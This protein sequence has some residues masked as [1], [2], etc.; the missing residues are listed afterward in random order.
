MIHLN[1]TIFRP[2]ML[3]LTGI[4]GLESVQFWIGI[5]FCAMYIIA[6]FGN[7][8]LLVV[9]KVERS[10]H[11]PMYLLLAMLGATDIALS[12][13]ILPKML[14]IFWFHLPNIYFDACLLQMWLIHTFQ[15]IESGILFAMAMDRYVA[16]CDPLRHASIFTWRLLTQIGIGVT[17]RGALFV[18]PC[19]ILIKCRL[20][21]YWTTVVSHSYCEHM[22]IVKL[23]AEDIRVN[24]I[25]GLFVAFS[26][27]GLDII[28]I[29]LSYIRI[30]VT[31]FKLPQKEARLKAF[32]TCIA[33]IC[34][35]LEFYLLAFFSF[36]THRFGFH[37]P[38]YIHI[39]LSNLYLL[40]PPL[41]NP[42]VYGVK[43]KQ[44]RD[45]VSK[46]FFCKYPS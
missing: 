11:E 41:L 46:I 21:F 32:N 42:V 10:L 19:L 18:A 4:P 38:S 6:L 5:P 34:V 3:T 28:F 22:A 14:G 44:I 35:F 17:L 2:S 7:S 31:V 9:I 39:L 27:L 20:K 13:C 26:I 45:Q 15:S 16:I 23:A 30:F 40:V 12:T 24:K 25:Y 36:F 33:H 37:I 8:L 43:T 29:T 1:S